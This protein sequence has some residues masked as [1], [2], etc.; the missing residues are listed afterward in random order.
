[1]SF[2]TKLYKLDN[3]NKTQNFIK[4]KF[5]IFTLNEAICELKKDY[6]YHMRLEK[7]KTYVFYGDCDGFQGN[8]DDFAILLK[9]F[10][11][12]YYNIKIKKKDISYTVNNSKK[13]LGGYFHYSI[14]SLHG[15]GSKILK[16]I[17]DNFAKTYEELTILIILLKIMIQMKSTAK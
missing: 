11:T 10:L 12:K 14:P 1:M 7:D 8:F 4:N 9:D 6:G 2:N 17:H 13:E 5:R 16:E 15:I 3:Y